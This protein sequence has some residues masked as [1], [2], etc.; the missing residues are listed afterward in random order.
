MT[1]TD[2]SAV[3]IRPEKVQAPAT[4]A[5]PAVVYEAALEVRAGTVSSGPPDPLDLFS[6]KEE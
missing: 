2:L 1:K 6:P 5:P 3:P 4:Y